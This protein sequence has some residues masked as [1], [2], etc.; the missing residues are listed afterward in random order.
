VFKT[1]EPI[2]SLSLLLLLLL[3]YMHVII[4]KFR[5][6]HTWEN[7]QLT[8]HLIMLAMHAWSRIFALSIA[9]LVDILYIL[10]TMEIEAWE[11]P[12]VQG[13]PRAP[14]EGV[15]RRGP[16]I[17]RNRLSSPSVGPSG[18]VFTRRRHFSL[19]PFSVSRAAHGGGVGFGK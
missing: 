2:F 18:P 9:K 12:V 10:Y 4:P 16:W 11:Q 14:A 8:G 1:N 5:G 13:T 6:V 17:C 19:L 3:L 15:A 7:L